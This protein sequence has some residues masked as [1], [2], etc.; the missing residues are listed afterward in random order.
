M[1]KR[2]KY[3]VFSAFF[4][5]LMILDVV[6]GQCLND[7]L[8]NFNFTVIDSDPSKIPTFCT[9]LYING[10]NCIDLLVIN[11][12]FSDWQN[13]VG[14]A[15]LRADRM[16][17]IL[18]GLI[19]QTVIPA[20]IPDPYAGI[21]EPLPVSP[22]DRKG[23]GDEDDQNLSVLQ[24]INKTHYDGINRCLRDYFI[25]TNGLWCMFTSNVTKAYIRTNDPVTP[26]SL[27][28]D[29]NRTAFPLYNCLPLID[30]YCLLLYGISISF[31]DLP[32]GGVFST[33]DGPL[34]Y[35]FCRLLRLFHNATD[36]VSIN[37]TQALLIN[38][39]VF[40]NQIPFIFTDEFMDGLTDYL[41]GR[42]TYNWQTF[43]KNCTNNTNSSAKIGLKAYSVGDGEKVSVHGWAAIPVPI[44]TFYGTSC[45]VSAM[46]L[47]LLSLAT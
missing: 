19:N 31:A 17:Q 18:Q 4:S 43:V 46:Q 37:Y 45:I 10:A 5:I 27:H 8:A 38:Q 25:V 6:F 47:L 20:T 41:N 24:R 36:P 39:T 23:D 40:T 15:S 2:V 22:G 29:L 16:G 14:N 12:T 33:V 11:N 21:D 32:F 28:V 3:D 1:T 44:F 35:S 34:S 26:L 13:Y 7:D 9:N 30:T 42:V